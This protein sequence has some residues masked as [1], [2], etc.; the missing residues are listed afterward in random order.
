MHLE[1]VLRLYEHLDKKHRCRYSEQS[2]EAP[3]PF[4]H[5]EVQ[6]STTTP[7]SVSASHANPQENAKTV[8]AYGHVGLKNPDAPRG[9][10]MTERPGDLIQVLRPGPTMMLRK[11]SQDA[12]EEEDCAQ[13]K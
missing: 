8:A 1:Y 11:G 2:V 9:H 13:Q 6:I 7:Q 12:D 3:A 10:L 5:Q 4:T